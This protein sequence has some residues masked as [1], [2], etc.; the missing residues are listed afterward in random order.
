ALVLRCG[1][2]LN[3][4]ELTR[5]LLAVGAGLGELLPELGTGG[6]LWRRLVLTHPFGG[7]RPTGARDFHRNPYVAFPLH[8][9]ACYHSPPPEWVALGKVSE[10]AAEGGDTLLLH[11]AEWEGTA[12]TLKRDWQNEGITWELPG[13]VTPEE[14][15]LLHALAGVE[16]NVTAPLLEQHD[17]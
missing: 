2:R 12:Q 11:V 7:L 16:T 15:R 5:L 4:E 3:A 14:T 8:T 1:G 6:A 10:W 9:D 17:G 13:P